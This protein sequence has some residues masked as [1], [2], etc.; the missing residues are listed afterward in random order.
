VVDV[1]VRADNL[2]DGEPVLSE[3]L[4]DFLGIVAGIDDNRFPRIFIAEDRAIA[5]E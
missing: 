2:F 3:T 4:E 5:F 1:G